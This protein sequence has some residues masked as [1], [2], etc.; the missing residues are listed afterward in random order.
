MS[1]HSRTGTTD[2]VHSG[3]IAEPEK[4]Q[5][6]VYWPAD[7]AWRTI[8]N[9]RILTYGYDTNIRHRV[10]GPVSKKTVYEHAWDLLCALEAL[11][12]NESARGRP[13]LFVAHS[14]GGIVVKQALRRSRDAASTKVHL[15]DIFEATVGVLFFGT[16]HKGA[17]PRNLLHHLLSA[18]AQ[19]LGVQ[20]NKTIVDTLMPNS[21]RLSDLGDE[22]S[23]MCHDRKWQIYSFQEEYGIGKLFGT[24]VVD[25]LSSCLGDP[26]VETKLQIS[27][28]HIDMCRF[29]GLQD[30]EYWK[31]AAA[32]T[33]IL[34]TETVANAIS[35]EQPLDH[36][37]PPDV[38][39]I[40]EAANHDHS[41]V[42]EQLQDASLPLEAQSCME[43]ALVRV[44]DGIDASL[45]QSLVEQLY[46]TKI[47]ERLTSLTAAQ[48]KTCRW[49]LA[50]PDYAA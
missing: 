3:N 29:S 36:R 32:M 22:F 31:V 23:V 11:R 48:G 27:S 25:D 45:Q 20:V 16:P 9:S 21:D 34:G 47:D 26:T 13:L 17:D 46:F 44:C 12:R 50:K 2:D 24:K 8:P 35:H 42:N 49:F 5:K 39:F 15:H 43:E 37:R 40:N 38:Y 6:E 10:K 14:L 19:A 7:L 18:S 28:N 1:Q 41:I 33:F 4:P 30:P